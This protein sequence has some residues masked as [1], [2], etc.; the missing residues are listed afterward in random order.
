MGRYH[1]NIVSIVEYL[2]CPVPVMGIEIDHGGPLP[3]RRN[4]NG[5]VIEVAES[6]DAV[7]ACVVARGPRECHGRLAARRDLDRFYSH[8]G[9]Y[10]GQLV[11]VLMYERIRVN[12]IIASHPHPFH[13]LLRMHSEKGFV[14]QTVRAHHILPETFFL[15]LLPQGLEPQRRL[16]MVGPLT[17]LQ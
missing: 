4:G 8:G 10:L 3:C 16:G 9:G 7:P 14:R 17:V 12:G 6:A 15:Q 11:G 13:V 1:E 5:N 2:L